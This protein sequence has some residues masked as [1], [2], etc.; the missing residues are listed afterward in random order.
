MKKKP[1]QVGEVNLGIYVEN[2][3]DL[4]TKYPISTLKYI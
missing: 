3:K 2:F 1:D 4:G